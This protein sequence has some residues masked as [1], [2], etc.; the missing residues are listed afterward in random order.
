MQIVTSWMEQGLERGERNLIL[1]QLTRRLGALSDNTQQHIEQLS[2][3]Q[4]EQL[5]DD[6]L[7]FAV[8]ADLQQ[9]LS[10]YP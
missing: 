4:L 6:L 3:V 8:M 5:G 2:L 7:D 1:R 9:W 10:Q